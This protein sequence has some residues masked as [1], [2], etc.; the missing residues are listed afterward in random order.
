MVA[1]GMVFLGLCLVLASLII[2]SVRIYQVRPDFVMKVL[3]YMLIAMF[4]LIFSGASV[5]IGFRIS[6]RHQSTYRKNSRAVQDIWGGQIFQSPPSLYFD[7]YQNQDVE[8]PK[9]GKLETRRVKIAEEIGFIAQDLD[10]QVKSNIR[11]KGLLKFAGYDLQFKGKYLLKNRLNRKEELHF[12]FK[13][14]STA[15]NISNTKVTID[16]KIYEGDTNYA[17][18]INWSQTMQ[19]E[20]EH[21]IEIEYTARGT[22][23]FTYALA[24]KKKEIKSLQAK[25]STD[26]LEYNIPEK[27]MVPNSQSSDSKQTIITWEGKNMITG[28]NIS[29]KFV[30]EDYGYIASKLFFYAP[31][32]LLLFLM[33]ILVYAVSKEINLHPMHYLFITGGFFVFYLL[34]SYLISYVT[35]ILGIIL[36]LGISTGIMIYY[37]HLINKGKSLMQVIGSVALIFQWIFS[38]AFFFPEHTGFLITIATVFS[39]IALMRTT[40]QTEWENKF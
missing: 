37:S 38:L 23:R 28:Q 34:G 22:D 35:V 7:K 6:D 13:L 25:L 24:D 4:W 12:L 10:I 33:A 20:E 16:G 19:K 8:N 29:L 15:G 39:F 21:S 17:D 31:L 5:A 18:G 30:I 32:S 2:M 3:K 36:S 26:F 27:A 40:A 9:T 14:P 11:Q 1:S